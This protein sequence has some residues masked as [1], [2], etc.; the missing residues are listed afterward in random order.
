MPARSRISAPERSASAADPYRFGGRFADLTTHVLKSKHFVPR[1]NSH[2]SQGVGPP[3]S[4]AE[5]LLRPR[6]LPFHPDDPAPGE[7]AGC[8]PHGQTRGQRPLTRCSRRVVATWS[9]TRNSDSRTRSHH[10]RPTPI[11]PAGSREEAA[12]TRRSPL[13]PPPD[14]LLLWPT[15][16]ALGVEIS[17]HVPR[18]RARQPLVSR[19]V[20]KAGHH[21]PT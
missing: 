5:S 18:H 15:E 11:L 19:H 14:P 21:V 9:S 17:R 13:T 3:T 4:T 6:R 20:T 7:F 8:V 2:G 10:P 1:S 16:P 12:R